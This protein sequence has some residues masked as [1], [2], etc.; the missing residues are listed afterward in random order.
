[1]IRHKTANKV[2]IFLAVMLMIFCIGGWLTGLA[3][4]GDDA[5]R[6]DPKVDSRI[7]DAFE[8]KDEKVE[9]IVMLK[10]PEE[11]DVT[12]ATAISSRKS[13]Q[14]SVI[15]SYPDFE[16]KY[17]YNSFNGFSGR[18]SKNDLN[19]LRFNSDVDG[20][21]YNEVLHIFLDESVPLINADYIHET[22]FKNNNLKGKNQT[23]CVID[24]GVDYTHP[25]LSGRVISGWNYVNNDSNYMDDE[26][27][28]THVAGIMASND[29]TYTG[30]AP[31]ANIVA[32]KACNSAGGCRTDN[33]IKGVD[34]CISNSSKYNISVI[35]MSLGSEKTYSSE[36]GD[37]EWN[38][39]VNNALAKNILILAAS[40]NNGASNGITWPACVP[41]ITS[42]G[43]TT[44]SDEIFINTNTDEILDLLAP[45]ENIKSTVF[46]NQF[47]SNTGTSMATPHVAGVAAL[48]YQDAKL[49]GINIT[50]QEVRDRMKN[51]G[52]NITDPANNLTFPRVD[53]K[54]AVLLSKLETGDLS[55]PY[56]RTNYNITFYANYTNK[57]NNSVI[58]N[59][60]CTI[61][62]ND[63]SANMTYNISE[64][65]YTY[66]RNYNN[67]GFYDYNITCNSSD[68]ETLIESKT[69]EVVQGSD[70]CTYAG[71]NR[72]WYVTV[73][74]G[75][76]CIGE[77]L[78][79]NQS[80]ISIE[81][82]AEFVLNDSNLTLVGASTTYH[83][84][85][86][87]T[88]T[89]NLKNVVISGLDQSNRI[90]VKLYGK[91]NILNA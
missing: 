70:N 78:I 17:R 43:A 23:I 25:A 62:F 41:N 61:A 84:N 53:A 30:V 3:T 13:I 8:D 68:F 22:Q 67:T 91:G 64:K 81:P 34:W 4:L 37:S 52:K 18:I 65:I 40:G 16:V 58:S 21:Y 26:G 46:N 51:T 89:F 36:C 1:M 15:N 33:V 12:S 32:I 47:D 71:S 57:T 20:I 60:N 56:P 6:E 85:V 10:E 79:L 76:F 7:V 69:I 45:G 28:G 2:M 66:S 82:G 59:S 42:V 88:S 14:S 49:A 27:H 74:N 86:S 87:S 80:N 38:N 90:D 54:K 55:T 50:S 35:S 83:I 44:N 72:T 9:V 63:L 19:K 31:E 75:S 29:T 39:A 73:E 24:T 11:R 48:I 5:M 77:N